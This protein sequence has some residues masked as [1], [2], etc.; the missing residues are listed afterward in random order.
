MKD[1]QLSKESIEII[2]K[3]YKKL[4]D[5]QY[6]KTE[7]IAVVGMSCR[8]PQANNLEE[9][10]NLLSQ[11][12][13]G[14]SKTPSDRYDINAYYT[15]QPD[16]TINSPHGGYVNHSVFDF[17]TRFFDLSPKEAQALDPQQRLLLE[18]TVEALENAN[19]PTDQ[20]SQVSTSVYVGISSFDYGARLQSNEGAIDSYLGTGT[21]LSPAAGRISYFLNLS[22]P[23]LVIDTACSS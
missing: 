19:L 14:I 7:P 8:F 15:G 10:W 11:N 23:S 16:D 21:L 9:Y 3:A 4:K 20:L 2:S 12:I 18:Q 5:I 13:D 22:G 6:Q 1:T 17:D